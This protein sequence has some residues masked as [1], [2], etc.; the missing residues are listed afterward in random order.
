MLLQVSTL[1]GWLDV[2][3]NSMDAAGVGR[4]AVSM[5]G[6]G[7]TMFFIVMADTLMTYIVYTP[8]QL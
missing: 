8:I 2:M 6:P 4:M 3:D 5:N 7:N 1:E